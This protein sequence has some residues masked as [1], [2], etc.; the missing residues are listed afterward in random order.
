MGKPSFYSRQDCFNPDLMRN[1]AIRIARFYNTPEPQVKSLLM[2]FAGSFEERKGEKWKIASNVIR[3]R[4]GKDLD[5]P[6]SNL[7]GQHK[8]LT[9][10]MD[11][12]NEYN[13]LKAEVDEIKDGEFK[14]EVKQVEFT[15]IKFG[16]RWKK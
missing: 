5:L 12:K 16:A 2:K 3:E 13:D 10:Q 7:E 6:H 4:I 14:Q 8:T 15:R 1:M 9:K 11:Y